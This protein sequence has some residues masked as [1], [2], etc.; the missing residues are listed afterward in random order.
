MQLYENRVQ[1]FKDKLHYG[2]MAST[3]LSVMIARTIVSTFMLPLEVLRVRLSN[4]IKSE[5]PL[6][7]FSGFKVT[8]VRDL[9]YSMLFWLTL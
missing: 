6:I 5:G 4:D 9:S 2:V 7:K 1:Y 8:L 3:F